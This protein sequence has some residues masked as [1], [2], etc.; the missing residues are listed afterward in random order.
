MGQEAPTGIRVRRVGFRAGTDAELSAM[1]LVE[2]EIHSERHPGSAGQP[3]QSYLAFAR[4]LPTHFGDHT[5]VA[6]ESDGTAVG[7]AACWSNEAGDPRLMESYVY[8]RQPW[9]RQGVG[10]RLARAVADEALREARANLVWSTY[11]AVPAGDAFSRRVGGNVGRVNRNSELLLEEVDWVRVQSWADE[12]PRRAP[13]YW[14]QVWNGPFPDHMID[15]A[16]RFHRIMN[17]QPRDDLEVG[18]VVLDPEQIAQLDQHLL[19]SGRQRW[20]MFVR[21]PDGGCV[22]GTEVTFEPWE[23]SLVLQ[24]NTAIDPDHR[25]LGLAK[26]AKATMLLRLRSDR[27]EVL[28]VRTGNA[29]SNHAMLAINR[30]L[31]FRITEVRT[32]WQGSLAEMHERLPAEGV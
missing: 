17:T 3:L 29:F 28:R 32:E 27:P 22:G 8:V 1:H 26:W 15:D 23:P 19:E 6:E 31:G 5:W 11:D 30:A 9:R 20:T 13:G 24:Q 2:V 12:G 14:M 18:D 4:S 10:S 16:C 25:D 7:C 21:D